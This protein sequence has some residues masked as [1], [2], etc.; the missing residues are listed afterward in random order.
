ML[1]TIR[2]LDALGVETASPLGLHLRREREHPVPTMREL[3]APAAG[4]YPIAELRRQAAALLDTEA[5]IPG[6]TAGPVRPELKGI[7]DLHFTGEMDFRVTAGWGHAGKEGVT[8]PGKGKLLTRG[9]RPE[10]EPAKP[11]Y[12][13]LGKSTHDVYLNDSAYWRNVPEKV[14]DFT[15]GGFKS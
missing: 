12:D 10:E 8:M 2:R 9:Y 14:W 6:V 7:A 15:L 3:L 5:P 13:L 11:L 4:L 1:E